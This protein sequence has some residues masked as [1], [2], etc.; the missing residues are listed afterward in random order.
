MMMTSLCIKYWQE[1][2][3]QGF[4]TGIDFGML[5]LPSVA[6][7]SQYFSTKSA[8]ASG[9]FASGSSL[10]G[11][12]VLYRN[13]PDT[14]ASFRLSMGHSDYCVQIARYSGNYLT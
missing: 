13:I 1:Y 3:A 9:I 12:C 8:F 14:T 4:I 11:W 5:F 10:G 7:V 6:I 2:L